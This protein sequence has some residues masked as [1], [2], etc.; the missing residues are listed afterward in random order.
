MD[1]CLGL[2]LLLP[3]PY[4]QVVS[5]L[6]RVGY[7]GRL[8][9]RSSVPGHSHCQHAHSPLRKKNHHTPIDGLMSRPAKRHPLS[10][11]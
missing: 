10:L 1:V 4:M 3:P 2:V 9:Y 6:K 5:A 8:V 11:S 7:G